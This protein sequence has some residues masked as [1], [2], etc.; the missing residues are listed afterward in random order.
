MSVNQNPEQ[1]A[2]DKI[3]AMLAQTGWVVQSKK[4]I[5]VNASMKT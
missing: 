5:N 1:I 4:K 2:C 3:D